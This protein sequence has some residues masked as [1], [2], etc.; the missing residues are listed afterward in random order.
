MDKLK[1][2]KAKNLYKKSKKLDSKKFAMGKRDLFA[3]WSDD[4]VYLR[5]RFLKTYYETIAH[6]QSSKITRFFVSK[7][8][9]KN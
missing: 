8:V 3:N 7:N 2:H 4:Y 5:A 6:E 1:T 9:G